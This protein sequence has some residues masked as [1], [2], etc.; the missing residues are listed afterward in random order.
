MEK[1][2]IRNILA[3][4]L[5]K[6]VTVSTSSE[7]WDVLRSFITTRLIKIKDPILKDFGVKTSDGHVVITGNISSVLS[8]ETLFMS[9]IDGLQLR[10]RY[11][12]ILDQDQK[13]IVLGESMSSKEFLLPVTNIYEDRFIYISSESD[14]RTKQGDLAF[15]GKIE[16]NTS[17]QGIHRKEIIGQIGYFHT[18]DLDGIGRVSVDP[19]ASVHFSNMEKEGRN[20][21]VSFA[22][23]DVKLSIDC[24]KI[25]IIYG[26]DETSNLQRVRTW[27]NGLKLSRM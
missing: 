10:G 25:P 2:S 19:S 23:N 27:I 13:S 1:D 17:E 6:Q 11:R 9:V 16:D 8:P 15:K 20:R 14:I 24:R 7:V 22:S 4:V 26:P 5:Q 21:V 12:V 3:N 18:Y